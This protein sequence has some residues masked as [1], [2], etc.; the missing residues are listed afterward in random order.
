MRIAFR[1]L[2]GRAVGRPTRPGRAA[3]VGRSCRP[4]VE[5]LEDRLVLSPITRVQ[6]IGTAVISGGTPGTTMTIPIPSTG[7]LAGDTILVEAAGG[8]ISG[9]QATV[10]DTGGNVYTQDARV[11]HISG[12]I[13]FVF[14]GRVTTA[15]TAAD[16]ITFSFSFPE[17]AAAASATEFSGL[18][19]SPK[20]Q[21]STNS[22]FNSGPSNFPDS[23]PTPVT[24]QARELLLGAIGINVSNSG[25][26]PPLFTFEPPRHTPWSLLP[27]AGGT[28]SSAPPG[29][30]RVIAIEPEIQVVAAIGSYEAAGTIN[31]ILGTDNTP[32]WDAAIVTYKAADQ[33]TQF[34]VTPSTPNPQPGV[35]FNLTVTALDANGAL[36]AGY[37]GTVHLDS[38]LQRSDGVGIPDPGA[39]LPADFTFG[40]ADQGTHTFTGL[41]LQALGTHIISASDVS[42]VEVEAVGSVTVT[43]SGSGF[44]GTPTQR[45]VQQMYLDLL[46]RPV[47]PAG[48][49]YWSGLID[50]GLSHTDAARLVQRSVEFLTDEVQAAYLHYLNRRVD[51]AGLAFYLPL[52]ETGGTAEHMGGLIVTSG[53]YRAVHGIINGDA[54]LDAVYHDVLNRAVDPAGRAIC[55]R[56]LAAGAT[57]P[58]IAAVIFGSRECDLGLVNRDFTRYLRRPLDPVATVI[59]VFALQDD[60]ARD[61]DV[62]AVIVGSPEY[63]ARL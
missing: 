2:W 4:I 35:P 37:T 23:G 62:T 8:T 50:G 56:N 1:R 60:G 28:T 39:Q 51:N 59:F 61:E 12:Q 3:E 36:S 43:V 40:P 20:D 14:S 49:R 52:L 21:S 29:T 31:N 34:R 15:L 19:V 33:T 5:R 7:V 10:T 32:E 6:D 26:N 47:D 18:A 9:I 44:T 58:Q 57:L 45:F 42:S 46:N 17:Q 27:H 55:D 48:L 16:H 25:S 41:V 54:F 53:E 22:S 63:A 13:L 24:T 30:T 11:S 38:I